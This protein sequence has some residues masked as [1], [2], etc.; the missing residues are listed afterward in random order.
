MDAPN[1]LVL[2]IMFFE[3]CLLLITAR[4]LLALS[5]GDYDLIRKIA[6]APSVTD[7]LKEQGETRDLTALV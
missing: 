7:E 4:V 5:R 3:F 2:G 1:S 6:A